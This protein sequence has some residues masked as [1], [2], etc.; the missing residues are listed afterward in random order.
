MKFNPM[1]ALLGCLLISQVSLAE[2]FKVALP[3]VAPF[4]PIS[5]EI[6]SANYIGLHL[7]Y[8]LFGL[9][10]NGSVESRFLDLSKTKSL[11]MKFNEF[12]F[13]LK[14]RLM[15]SDNSKIQSDDLQSSISYLAELYP[16][17]IEVEQIINESPLCIRVKLKSS[18][19]NLFKKLTGIASTVLKKEDVK[20]TY[21]I[22]YG[23][24]KIKSVLTDSLLLET[25]S[26][27][28]PRFNEIEFRKVKA[29]IDV[30]TEHFQDFNQM[31]SAKDFITEDS[32]ANNYNIPSL[33]VYSFVLN[34]STSKERLCA[35]KSLA[36]GKWEKVY[37]LSLIPQKSFLPW[38]IPQVSWKPQA[39]K[40]TQAKNN[41]P[42]LVAEMYDSKF[43]NGELTRI[44]A[45]KSFEVITL[46][47]SDF[48]KWVFSGKPYVAMM[49][50]DS[51]SS[52]AS[53]DGDFSYYFEAFFIK[54]NR[55]ITKPIPKLKEMIQ[56][57]MRFDISQKVREQKIIEAE[58][59]LL[60]EA[61]ILPV[62]RLS[63]KIIFPEDVKIEEW[64]DKL[65][66]FPAIWAIK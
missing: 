12:R 7:Y 22:G 29:K 51:S 9:D 53:L 4:N 38:R 41:I 3:I 5:N 35:Q 63:H 43:I 48:A 21:P 60:D 44:G 49:G 20:K 55:I 66:G 34:L 33:K 45:D 39:V 42:F 23:Q 64:A 28:K 32:N 8:P 14:E 18:T 26:K 56:D 24:Y 54:Q 30:G 15:F 31:P 10:K 6:N 62:G 19:P 46:S 47:S 65:N 27:S 36:D 13:C 52:K 58:K 37:G 11:S 16:H 17:L 57:S 50:F 61:W 40:C 59:L 1:Y 25:A 2:T